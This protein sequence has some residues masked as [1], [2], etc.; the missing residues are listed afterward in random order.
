MKYN[1]IVNEIKTELKKKPFALEL[2]TKT[3]ENKL[4]NTCAEMSNAVTVTRMGYNDHGKVHSVIIA[5]SAITIFNLLVDAGVKP[6]FVAEEHGDYED[7]LAITVLGALTHDIGNCVHREFHHLH[8]AY[9][10]EKIAEQVIDKNKKNREYMKLAIIEA[11]FSHDE[12]VKSTSI[13]SG[14]IKV[15]DGT[16]CTKGR[17]RIPYRLFGKNDIHAISALAIK[18]VEIRKGTDKYIEIVVDM[19]NPAGI[20]QINEVMQKKIDASNIKQFVK[21]I[22]LVNGKPYSY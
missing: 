7:S 8:G 2:F 16:D 11:V 10:A 19:E 1:D 21:V 5:R 15:A 18:S 14:I 9:L 6:T 22:P 13:E 17:A 12:S 20:F 4:F 3:I